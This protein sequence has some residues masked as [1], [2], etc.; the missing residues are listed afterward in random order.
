M[1]Y[2]AEPDLLL[3]KRV[4]VGFVMT[5][6]AR[7]NYGTTGCLCQNATRRLSPWVRHA[8]FVRKVV[9]E[10]ERRVDGGLTRRLATQDCKALVP[11]V[12]ARQGVWEQVRNAMVQPNV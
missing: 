3:L 11:L 8:T 4:R 1:C 12:L 5:G 2:R 7:Q 6:L 10:V 9:K